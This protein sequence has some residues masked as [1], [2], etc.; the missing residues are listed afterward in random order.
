[1][2]GIQ[3]LTG[4]LV[5]LKTFLF[6]PIIQSYAD[7]NIRPYDIPLSF[8]KMLHLPNYEIQDILSQLI[9][10]YIYGIKLWGTVSISNME[11]LERFQSKVFA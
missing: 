7:I 10:D 5:L 1:L 3:F 6:V 2:T 4:S 11:I 9:S 8:V